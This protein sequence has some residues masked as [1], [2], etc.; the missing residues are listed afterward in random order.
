MMGSEGLMKALYNLYWF[1]L[2][3]TLN[4]KRILV[5]AIATYIALC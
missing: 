1:P 5:L 4:K 2:P 3:F